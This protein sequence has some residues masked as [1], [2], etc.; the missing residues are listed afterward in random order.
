MEKKNYHKLK[1]TF[2]LAKIKSLDYTDYEG[3]RSQNVL[4]ILIII[5]KMTTT[6]TT[7]TTNNNN[8]SVA[9]VRE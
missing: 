7:T 6:T 1:H 9:F 5:I 4:L 8:N 3:D 2:H